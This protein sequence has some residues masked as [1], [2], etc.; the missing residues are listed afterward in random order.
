MRGRQIPNEMLQFYIPEFVDQM[1][2][3]RAVAYQ[4]SRL[5]FRI[6]DEELATAIRSILA[7]YFP[8]GEINQQD[9][10]RFLAQ[11][12]TTVDQFER[13]LRT[14]LLM[15]RLQNLAL[16]GIIVTPTEVEHEY[17]RRNEKVKLEY[18]KFE[19]G[20]L[21]SKVNVT[22]EEVREYYDSQKAQFTI[23]E[24]R[25][26]S[27]LVADQQQIA[28]SVQLTDDQL[29]AAYNTQMEQFRTPERVNVRHILIKTTD[30]PKEEIPKLEAKAKDLL[31]QLRNGADFAK[32][33]RENSED[34]GSAVK[35]GE[36]GWIT[37]GQTVPNFE[38]AAFTLKPKELSN[39]IN[40][41]YGYHIL[42]VES[43]EQARVKPFEEVKE[44]IATEMKQ[45]AVYDR[46]QQAIDQARNEI[47]QNPKGA[48]QIAAKHGLKFVHVQ[49]SAANDAIPEVGASP[50]LSGALSSLRVN[51][52]TPVVQVGQDKLAVA[53]VTEVTPSRQAEFAEVEDKA[54]DQLINNKTQQ[55]AQQRIKEAQEKLKAATDLK[56]A[57]ASVGSQ[58][59]TT[60]FFAAE[61]AAEG[62]GPA[63]YLA[64][65]FTKPVGS[66]IGPVTI[67]NQVF[68]AKVAEKQSADMGKLAAE[69][70]S[71]VLGLKRQKAEERKVLFEDGLLT[72]LVKEGTVKKNQ[73]AINRVVEM[74]RG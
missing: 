37:R 67:G 52:V 12:G 49:K 32:L 74:Y 45:Q 35:G 59:K 71:I 19:A 20:D 9:Y 61:G 43:K 48:E 21:R 15:L 28:A 10:V 16:E 41:E 5:G 55:L 66:L 30:K 33:A 54:R 65:A 17:R 18:V 22:P 34:P 29:R 73:D 57:A 60:D 62:I 51:E 50:E 69:R 2:T 70:E 23:P 42:Q 4:A 11:Q 7:S 3:E 27:V 14:N 31:Q 26:F 47:E 72:Q 63:T 24:Q 6:T 44:Q 56:A 64:D 58:V 36:L 8:G 46:M 1:I 39:V 40:T 13:N 68:L 53:V 25:S 38:S